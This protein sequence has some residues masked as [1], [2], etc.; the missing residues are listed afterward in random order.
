[1]DSVIIHNNGFREIPAQMI[2]LT[3]E[4]TEKKNPKII[5]NLR[6]LVKFNFRQE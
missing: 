3:G 4:K 5:K 1:M 6:I 2:K